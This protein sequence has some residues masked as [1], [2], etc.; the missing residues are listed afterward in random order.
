MNL[1]LESTVRAT[2]FSLRAQVGALAGIIAG[3][4]LGALATERGTGVA[5]IASAT[6]LAPA[7]VLYRRSLVRDGPLSPPSEAPTQSAKGQP[8]R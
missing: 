2:V 3:P 8:E 1:D 6:A 5:L 4:L 7:L